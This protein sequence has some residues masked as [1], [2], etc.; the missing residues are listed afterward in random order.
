[1]TPVVAPPE[2]LGKAGSAGSL[3]ITFA[4]MLYA[5]WHC[6]KLSRVSFSRW[7]DLLFVFFAIFCALAL[8]FLSFGL[9]VYLSPLAG[10]PVVFVATAVTLVPALLLPIWLGREI[11][12]R[13]KYGN[14]PVFHT[15]LFIF[16]LLFSFCFY[17]L[18]S[19]LFASIA[20]QGGNQAFLSP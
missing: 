3:I 7:Y 16:I 5:L 2:W 18:A 17:T 8:V 19:L 13:R 9:Y 1:M 4:G 6:C 15:V 12:E 20:R 10:D 14:T 11:L